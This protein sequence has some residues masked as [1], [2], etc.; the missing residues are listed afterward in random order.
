M[1]DD[2]TTEDQLNMPAVI[3]K[4]QNELDERETKLK[5]MERDLKE[6]AEEVEKSQQ[7]TKNSLKKAKKDHQKTLDILKI[8]EGQD[9]FADFYSKCSELYVLWVSQKGSAE[10]FVEAIA[11]IVKIRDS[12]NP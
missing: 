4:R 7:E 10:D 12:M 3:Q 9:V 11:G 2:K 6:M 8:V 5:A 1:A